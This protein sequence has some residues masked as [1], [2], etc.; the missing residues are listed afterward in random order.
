MILNKNG[1]RYIQ[2]TFLPGVW[3][4]Y[5]T[6]P[7]QTQVHAKINK[8]QLDNQLNDPIFPVVLA[9]IAPPKSVATTTALKPFVEFSVVQRVVPNSNVKQFKYCSML[10]QEFHIKVDLLF[11]TAVANLFADTVSDEQAAKFFNENIESIRKPLSELVETHSLQEQKNFYDVLHLGPLKSHVSFSMA[12]SDTTALPGILSTLV[13]GIGVT[14]TDVNDVVFRLAFFEREYRFFTQRELQSEVLAHY[15]GQGLKQ[16]YVLVLGLD[17]LG[18]PYG[19]VVGL[20][21]GV[22]DLFYE[23]F[24][25]SYNSSA[26][27]L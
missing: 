2:R 14:L 23:P 25:V 22:E 3:I 9:P 4:S 13:Q 12:G 7:F 5:K 20:K 1:P 10:I 24:Q 6:S 11:L 16:L 18:N 15:A 26:I 8:I 17:V 19:L 27:S 21:K